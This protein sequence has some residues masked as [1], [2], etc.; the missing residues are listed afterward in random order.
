[1]K[2]S[3]KCPACGEQLRLARLTCP[4][5]KAEFPIDEPLSPY[6]QL[7]EEQARFLREFLVCAGS[8]KDVQK[9]MGISYP[10]A[11]KRLN[12]LLL[13]LGL[14]NEDEMDERKEV[15]NKE[16]VTMSIFKNANLNS[17]KAS[18]I[19]REKLYE[20][21]GR[22][23]VYSVTGKPYIIRA[24]NDGRTFLCNELPVPASQTYTYDVFDVIVEL[25]LSQDGVARKGNGR[26]YALG[27]GDCTLDTVV[28]AIGKNYFGATEGKYVFDPVF[29]LAS[30]LDWAG[31]AH[32]ER[33]YLRLT[34]EYLTKVQR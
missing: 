4:G 22:A 12:E 1:M 28:G 2:F 24:A 17:M 21:G 23:T 3:G 25:L 11:R 27:E 14:F 26:N 15:E 20:N 7:T 18:D 6:E 32:N 9:R 16:E 31:I 29:V 5:C 34:A 10:T 13:A 19:I 33:G 30:V 8:M